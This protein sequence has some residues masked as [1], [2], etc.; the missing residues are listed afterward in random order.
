MLRLV[1]RV[2]GRNKH[3]FKPNRSDLGNVWDVFTLYWIAFHVDVKNTPAWCEQKRRPRAGTS[4]L[5]M[6]H[7]VTAVGREGLVL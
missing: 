3:A 1:R 7:L 6:K 2:I 4:R 5:G